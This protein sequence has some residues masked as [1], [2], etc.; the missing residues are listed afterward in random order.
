MAVDLHIHVMDFDPEY[1]RVASAMCT[2]YKPAEPNSVFLQFSLED[3]LADVE[4]EVPKEK[5]DAAENAVMLSPS[6]WVG[7]FGSLSDRDD[8]AEDSP[9]AVNMIARLIPHDSTITVNEN[10]LARVYKIYRE[11]PNANKAG[12][13]YSVEEFM[14]VINFLI[15]NM[16][17]PVFRVGW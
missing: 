9:Y 16:G 11:H 15:S 6:V 2:G 13:F 12:G 7:R 5:Y 4:E 14:P 3:I 1:L 10:L 8:S 17:K